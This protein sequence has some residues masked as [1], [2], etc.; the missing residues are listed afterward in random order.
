[1]PSRARALLCLLASFVAVCLTAKRA[2]ASPPLRS[3]ERLAAELLAAEQAF[4]LDDTWE[5]LFDWLATVGSAAAFGLAA[6]RAGRDGFGS[7]SL[8]WALIGTR[9]GGLR[10]IART[11]HRPALARECLARNEAVTYCVREAAERGQSLRTFR[12]AFNGFTAVAGVLGYGLTGSES[13]LLTAA[14]SSVSIAFD[15][16]PTKTE[17]LARKQFGAVSL[18]PIAVPRP[19]GGGFV[20]LAGSF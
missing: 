4:S 17:R 14:A 10:A 7:P 2:S 20:V 6:D 8:R 15:L 12:S 19:E 11:L 16:F 1:M 13:L 18:V 9:V 5:P 3:N